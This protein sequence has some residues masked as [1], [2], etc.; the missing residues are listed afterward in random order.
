M[1]LGDSSMMAGVELERDGARVPIILWA[2]FLQ[3][4]SS[5]GSRLFGKSPL[6]SSLSL[7]QLVST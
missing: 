1:M 3:M 4:K 7:M 2:V 6:P 5:I